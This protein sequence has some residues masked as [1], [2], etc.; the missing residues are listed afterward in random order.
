MK[1]LID[2]GIEPK[3]FRL[4]ESAAN[5]PAS[6]GQNY[7]LAAADGRVEVFVLGEMVGTRLPVHKTNGSS[8]DGLPTNSHDATFPP[9][10][11]SK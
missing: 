7:G 11:S 3:R 4:S 2:K 6:Q 8:P 5:E 10:A 1:Y 9:D